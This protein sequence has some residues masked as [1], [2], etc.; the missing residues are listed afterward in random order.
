MLKYK[1]YTQA[2]E[3][4]YYC[5]A[6]KPKKYFYYCKLTT[7]MVY[8]TPALLNMSHIPLFNVTETFVST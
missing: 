7:Y 4:N 2:L 5:N 8:G 1:D 6:F 3:V